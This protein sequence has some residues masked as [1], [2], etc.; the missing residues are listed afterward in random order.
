MPKPKKKPRADQDDKKKRSVS[1]LYD[2]VWAKEIDDKEV[3]RRFVLRRCK[4]KKCC[5]YCGC[6][7]LDGKPCGQKRTAAAHQKRLRVD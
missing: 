7:I 1:E 2:D 5:L 4:N 3:C 6:P